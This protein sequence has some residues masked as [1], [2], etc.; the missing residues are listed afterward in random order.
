MIVLCT[1]GMRVVSGVPTQNVT[2]TV[3]VTKNGT[4]R[5]MVILMTKNGIHNLYLFDL[6]SLHLPLSAS[7]VN[8]LITV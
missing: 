8:Y 7:H 4:R 3:A 5:M 6:G 2:K 1:I